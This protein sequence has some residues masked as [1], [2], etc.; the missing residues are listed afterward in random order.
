MYF[1]ASTVAI[2]LVVRAWNSIIRILY[3]YLVFGFVS[4]HRVHRI[5][6]H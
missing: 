5:I 1:I 2:S 4:F 6:F 3:Y